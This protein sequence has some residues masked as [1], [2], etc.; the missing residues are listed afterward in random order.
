MIVKESAERGKEEAIAGRLA[1]PHRDS[2]AVRLSDGRMR[3]RQPDSVAE[4]SQAR[5]CSACFFH[6]TVLKH[7]ERITEAD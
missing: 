7:P 2:A 6:Q 5:F 4:D 3:A 1:R